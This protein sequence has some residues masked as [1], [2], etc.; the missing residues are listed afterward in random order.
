M[1]ASSYGVGSTGGNREDLR[2][3]LTILEP[4]AF[5]FTS[6]VAKGPSPKST[7]V[8]HGADMYRKPDIGGTREGSSAPKGGNKTVKRR[9]FG[10]YLHR[11]YDTFGVTDVQQ[12]LTQAGGNAFTSNE[13]ATAKAKCIV[14]VKRDMEA[15]FLGDQDGQGGSDDAMKSRGAFK[16]LSTSQTPAVPA[17]FQ[18]PSAQ[19]VTGQATLKE[20]GSSSLNAVLKSLFQTYGA[21]GSYQVFA[22]ADYVEDIDEFSRVDNDGTTKRL[23]VVHGDVSHEIDMTV[24]IFKSSF[25]RCEVVPSHFIG[26]DASTEVADV[27][28]CLILN[29]DLWEALFLEDI[30]SADDEED[31]AGETGYVKAIGGLFCLNPKGNGYIEN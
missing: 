15:V 10:S 20:Y 6:M 22:G 7:L 2:G 29:M 25:G 14:E 30:H 28:S 21:K 13:Y 1:N 24:R 12:L 31:A 18:P 9:R 19:R 4:E 26:W 16:W 8:E 11:F 5:P 27:D 17:D 23:R 3:P